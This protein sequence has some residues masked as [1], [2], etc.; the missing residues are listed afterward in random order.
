MSAAPSTATSP[1]DAA[2]PARRD[3]PWSYLL[4][5]AL[6]GYLPFVFL[7][8]GTDID[9]ANVL[10]AGESMLDGDYHLSRGPG[11]APH[12][13]AT[14]VLDRV[15]GPILVNLASVAFGLLAI[16]SVHRLLERDGARWPVLATALLAANPWFWVAATSL[17]D[18]TWALALGL[19]GAVATK[20]DR[21]LLAGVLF[22]LGIGC[23]ASTALIALAWL[24]AER[25]GDEEDRPPWSATVRTA[26][27]LV[28][29]GGLCFVPPWLSVDRSLDFLRNEL[30]FAGWR[31]HAGRFAVKNLATAT[32]PGAAVLVLGGRWLLSGVGR[33]RSSAV[34]RFA[35]LTIVLC[36]LLFLRL[37]FKPVHLLPVVAGTALLIGAARLERRRWLVALLA[38]QLLAG[39]VGATIAA[40]DTPDDADGGRL[41]VRPA[42][43]VVVNDMRCRLADLDRGEWPHGDSSAEQAEATARA[44]ANFVCQRDAWRDS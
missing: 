10:R 3:L 41:S 32:L 23:R 25:S 27:T 8:Y 36:E 11:A 18:F 16:W 40:P 35:V 7:G 26:V 42:D 30:E 33:W 6:V 14:A 24:V 17:G 39:F 31:V 2:H 4:L 21:R 20:A 29:V 43:G 9:V 15:G 44:E 28:V 19:A 34:V 1:A 5:G 37:P 22:G 12:E 13:V 38:A